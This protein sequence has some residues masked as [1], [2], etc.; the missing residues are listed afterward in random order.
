MYIINQKH[1]LIIVSQV[2]ILRDVL[3]YKRQHLFARD[4]VLADL[5]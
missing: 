1:Y 2:K 3:A 5:Q 4:A